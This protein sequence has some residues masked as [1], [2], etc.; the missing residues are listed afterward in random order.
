DLSTAVAST[1]G[2]SSGSAGSTVGTVLA[3]AN[4]ACPA[5]KSGDHR[6]IKFSDGSAQV[7]TI[8]AAK[9]TVAV[10]GSSYQ[11]TQGATACDYTLNDTGSTR[12]LVAK[13]GM[14]V[15]TNGSGGTGVLSLSLPKQIVDPTAINGN[16]I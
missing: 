3:P 15:W 16:Y 5:L 4:S 2:S 13:S 14:A 8:D 9:L 10:G 12:V 11:L 6:L 7:V 1:S